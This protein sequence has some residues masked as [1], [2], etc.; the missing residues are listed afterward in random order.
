MIKNKIIRYRSYIIVI[1]VSFLVM[2]IG[3]VIRGCMPFGNNFPLAGNG[4]FQDYSSFLNAVKQVKSGR[5]FSFLDYGIG[6]TFEN[7]DVYNMRPWLYPV[8]F[9]AP[10]SLYVYIFFFQYALFFILPGPIFIYYLTH[11]RNGK[12]IKSDDPVLIVLGLCYALSVYSISFFI[13]VFRYMMIIPIVFLGIEKMVYDK[14][15]RLYIIS[16]TYYMIMDAYYAFILCIFS[17]LYFLILKHKNIRTFFINTFRFAVSSVCSAGLAASFLIPYFLKTRNSPYGRND[18]SLPSLLKWFGSIFYPLSEFR[19]ANTGMVTSP[20]EYR[21]NIYCGLLVI[22]LV[23]V[24]VFLKDIDII[25]RI[26]T[27][28]LLV[29]IYLGFDNQLINFVFHGFHYQWQVPNRF[30]CFFIFIILVMFGDVLIRFKDIDKKL[31]LCSCIISGAI[32][33]ISYFIGAK[34]PDLAETGMGSF[35]FSFVFLGTYFI[36]VLLNYLGTIKKY[37]YPFLSAVLIFE[38]VISSIPTFMRTF[39]NPLNDYEMNYVSDMSKLVERHSDMKSPYVATERPG[40]MYNQDIAYMT[41]SHSVSYYSSRSFRQNFDLMYRWGMLFSNNITYYTAGSPLA[42]MMLHVKYHVINSENM[43]AKSPY[44]PIDCENNIY[45]FENPY[46]LPL[47]TLMDEKAIS[48]WA[49]KS[50]TYRNYSSSFERDNKFA[51]AIGVDNIYDTFEIESFKDGMTE[52]DS[53]YYVEQDAEGN[54]LY[55]FHFGKEEKGKFYLQIAQALEYIGNTS[56]EGNDLYFYA[57]KTINTGIQDSM[58]IGVLNEENLTKLYNTLID[59]SMMNQTFEGDRITGVIES[60]SDKLLYLSMPAL[61]GFTAYIDGVESEIFHTMD[62]IGLRVG[63]GT[64]L[65]EL[66]Y[67]PEGFTIGWQI[68]FI[69]TMFLLIYKLL[70]IKAKFEEESFRKKLVYVLSVIYLLAAL[71]PVHLVFNASNEKAFMNGWFIILIGFILFVIKKGC[72]FDMGNNVKKRMIIVL[73]ALMLCMLPISDIINKSSLIDGFMIHQ[74]WKWLFYIPAL[75]FCSYIV[76]FRI[77]EKLMNCDRIIR[78]GDKK[79]ILDNSWVCFGIVAVVSLMFLFSTYPGI[80]M[81]DDVARVLLEAAEGRVSDWDTY[82]F[83]L[84]V[85][86]VSCGGQYPYNVNIVQTIIWLIINLY[87]IKGLDK[88]SKKAMKAYSLLC[89]LSMNPIIHLEVIFKDTVFSM[90]ILAL[91]A[92]VFFIVINK[93]IRKTDI[94]V[95]GIASLFATLCRQG[96]YIATIIAVIIISVYLIRNKYPCSNAKQ[97]IKLISIPAIHIIAYILVYIVLF[98]YNGV[99]KVDAYVKY[100]TPVSMIGAAAADGVEFTDSE[101]AELEKLMPVSTW[102]E[103]YD[104]YWVDNMARLWGDIGYDNVVKLNDLVKNEHYGAFIIKMNAKLLIKHPIVY[105]RAFLAMGNVIWEISSPADLGDY[106]VPITPLCKVGQF[107][108]VTYT[109][110]YELTQRFSEVYADIPLLESMFLR[111]GI[112]LFFLVLTTVV[113]CIKKKK[114]LILVYLPSAIYTLLLLFVIPAPDSRYIL[115]ILEVAILVFAIIFGTDNQEEK[116]R[117]N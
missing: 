113:L 86:V 5:F 55:S 45:L 100:G 25:I 3:M 96:G 87:I 15:S 74:I 50:E 92:G 64:H 91:S 38:V 82:G 14:S 72:P 75:V 83:L 66:R 11:R 32:L 39:E 104:K 52:D 31:I 94:L 69:F 4:Y 88:W 49:V 67:M 117:E 16:L 85:D 24:F 111:G 101:K 26:K 43:L 90:G 107:E 106:Y 13:Y 61:P 76:I 12:T 44:V 46:Y 23:P 79:D 108:E 84:F 8:Y 1:V 89:V 20:Y 62:G 99:P 29:L 112:S 47:G 110:V 21:V 33:I 37:V 58:I 53:Y 97:V 22:L 78:L 95:A 115:P 65:I 116:T 114:E 9:F 103:C 18:G 63:A 59:S 35:Y 41:D 56:E 17:G 6:L 57:Q 30:S 27:A 60:D 102:A 54:V 48:E 28:A 105:L 77:F 68:S 42:D 98:N 109:P 10:E 81:R 71:F 80:W 2:C 70:K 19:V 73:T 93:T 36:I 51:E 40:E 7:T 34:T